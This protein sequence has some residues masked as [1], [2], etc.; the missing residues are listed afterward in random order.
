L[1]QL[2]HLQISANFLSAASHPCRLN[3]EAFRRSWRIILVGRCIAVR[4]GRAGA[5]ALAGA[6]AQPRDLGVE[7]AVSSQRWHAMVM[8]R[9]AAAVT[10]SAIR[11]RSDRGNLPAMMA[12]RHTRY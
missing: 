6:I 5:A 10:A 8:R 3:F 7:P 4:A 11:Q 12:R 2:Q 1:M 9:A